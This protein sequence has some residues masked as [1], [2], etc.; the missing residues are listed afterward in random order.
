MLRRQALV[1]EAAIYFKHLF[2]AAN[3]KTLQVKLGR[4]AQKQGQIQAVMMRDKGPGRGA[5]RYGVH[6][7]RFHLH[8]TGL[9]QISADKLNDAK[10]RLE[11][12]ARRLVHDQVHITPAITQFLISQAMKLLRQGL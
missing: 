6:H 10:A 5:A 3:D 7:R 8:K 2:K 11:D 4:H 9:I 12:G 1:A